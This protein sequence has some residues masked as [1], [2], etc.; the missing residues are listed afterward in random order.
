MADTCV[1]YFFKPSNDSEPNWYSGFDYEF[2]ELTIRCYYNYNEKDKQ[3]AYHIFYDGE[4][5][6]HGVFDNIKE[7]LEYCQ[8]QVDNKYIDYK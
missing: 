6:E 5:D 4:H 3:I 1:P 8:I 7:T 2:Y